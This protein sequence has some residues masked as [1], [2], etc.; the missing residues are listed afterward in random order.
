MNDRK[1]ESMAFNDK[2]MKKASSIA[3]IMNESSKA[4]KI[5]TEKVVYLPFEKLRPN[6]DN[7]LSLDNLDGLKESLLNYGL[8]N[9][10]VVYQ[11][12]DG[13]YT[14]YAG[15]RRYYAITKIR[16]ES[17]KIYERRF[18]QVPCKIKKLEEIKLPISDALKKEM[19]VAETNVQKRTETMEDSLRLYE[20]YVKVYKEAIANGADLPYMREYITENMGIGS[21]QAGRL[22]YIL[23]NLSP[24]L[25]EYL[26]TLD[27]KKTPLIYEIAHMEEEEQK[28]F[29]KNN[30]LSTITRQSINEYKENKEVQKELDRRV[31][32]ERKKENSPDKGLQIKRDVSNEEKIEAS[33]ETKPMMVTIKENEFE[34]LLNVCKNI[35]HIFEGRKM[36]EEEYQELV[37]LKKVA[38]QCLKKIEKF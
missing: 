13:Y 10:F 1:G 5:E 33:T 21:G 30:D 38:S 15:N 18:S 31:K 34:E 7:N 6:Q 16:Q 27:K 26:N 37:I 14:V 4:A 8:D 19:M 35:N 32:E 29:V 9:N 3:S 12:E 11:E 23:K 36:T 2:M 17:P 20:I 28:E 25:R 24:D 22:D